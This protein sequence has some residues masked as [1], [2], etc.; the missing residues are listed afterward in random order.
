MTAI[1]RA[2]PHKLYNLEPIGRPEFLCFTFPLVLDKE[3]NSIIRGNLASGLAVSRL[4]TL[5]FRYSA[6]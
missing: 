6:S 2:L 5:N 3:K 4:G 1:V